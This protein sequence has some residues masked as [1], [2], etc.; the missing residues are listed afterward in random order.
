VVSYYPMEY[1]PIHRHGEKGVMEGV[2]TMD[3][4]VIEKNLEGFTMN[5]LDATVDELPRHYQSH[6]IGVSPSI[7]RLLRRV[8]RAVFCYNENNP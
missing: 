5:I 3:L 8:E 7:G 6:T 2:A 1:S 4:E